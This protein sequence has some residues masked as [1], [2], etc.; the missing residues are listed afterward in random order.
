MPKDDLNNAKPWYVYILL[1]ADNTYYTGITVDLNSRLEAH[2]SGIGAKYTRAHGAKEI[3]FFEE[4]KNQKEAATREAEIKKLSRKEKV[5][6]VK[7]SS[8]KS[9]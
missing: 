4:H 8:F 5:N 1:C 6:L 7:L 2:K 9:H 3:V